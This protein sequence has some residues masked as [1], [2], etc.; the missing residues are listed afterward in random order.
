MVEKFS[1][2]LDAELPPADEAAFESHLEDCDACRASWT[3]F[4]DA[5]ALVREVPRH[6]LPASFGRR[7]LARTRGE[8]RRRLV[9]VQEL[10]PFGPAEV[11]LGLVVLAAAAAA[12]V[13]LLAH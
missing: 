8:R 10:L 11:G 7:V 5:L 4:A 12:A 13:L 3:E 1:P 9:R 6:R 2:Y